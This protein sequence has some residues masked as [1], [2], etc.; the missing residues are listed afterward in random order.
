M[1]VRDIT[2]RDSRRRSGILRGVRVGG[3]QGYNG[4]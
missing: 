4:A 2:G 3:G 1:E